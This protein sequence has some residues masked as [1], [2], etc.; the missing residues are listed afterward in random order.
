LNLARTADGTENTPRIIGKVASHI[1]KDGISVS[2]LRERTL[3]IARHSEVRM[4]QKIERLCAK[5]NFLAF[6]HLKAFPK[7]Q[8]ELCE[9]WTS[10]GFETGAQAQAEGCEAGGLFG[11]ELVGQHGV[12]DPAYCT[13]P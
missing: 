12:I 3:R 5:N 2:S 9:G 10:Q 4:I 8:I 6:A 7:C 13:L 1:L 11:L